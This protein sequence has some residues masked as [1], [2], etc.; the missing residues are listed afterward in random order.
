VWVISSTTC[1]KLGKCVCYLLP[2]SSPTVP[3]KGKGFSFTCIHR[4]GQFNGCGLQGPGPS[5]HWE[6]AAFSTNLSSIPPVTSVLCP[7]CH[8][9]CIMGCR[10]DIG[11]RRAPGNS[12]REVKKPELLK[13][14]QSESCRWGR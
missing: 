1:E 6:A 3:P 2:W 8:T 9:P 5:P 7:L 10:E 12:A 4:M 14:K 11:G 13:A